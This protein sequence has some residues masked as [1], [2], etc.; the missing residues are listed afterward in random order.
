MSDVGKVSGLPVAGYKDQKQTAVDQV[1]LN[2]MM[3]EIV[4]R[5]ID[6][7]QTE[8]EVD[9]RWLAI[10]RTD[11]EKGFMALNRSIFKPERIDLS[12]NAADAQAA[13]LR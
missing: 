4:L 8:G 2:K 1:N 12:G 5:R 13:L 6:T 7:L 11:I 9:P 3:E 10:A